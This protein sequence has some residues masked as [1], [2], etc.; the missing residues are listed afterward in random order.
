MLFRVLTSTLLFVYLNTKSERFK[1]TDLN[2]SLPKR[3]TDKR[4]I[5]F[6]RDRNLNG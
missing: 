5:A 4:A 2:A 6:V 3:S 1:E